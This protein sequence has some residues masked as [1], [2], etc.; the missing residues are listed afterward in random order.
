[1]HHVLY[2]DDEADLLEVTKF[3]LE[4]SHEFTIDTDTSALETQ[5]HRG[6]FQCMKRSSLITRC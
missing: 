5:T 4:I 3:Y 2:I 6:S 1:M